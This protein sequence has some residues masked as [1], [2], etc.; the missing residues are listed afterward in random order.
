MTNFKKKAIASLVLFSTIPSISHA[1]FCS[2]NQLPW[3]WW[4]N[5]AYADDATSG[6]LPSPNTYS[7]WIGQAALKYVAT[8]MDVGMGPNGEG[9]IRFFNLDLGATGT[10]AAAFPFHGGYNGLDCAYLIYGVMHPSGLCN[11]T[12]N[13]A[14]YGRIRLNDHY[15]ENPITISYGGPLSVIMHEV[16]HL[17]GWN[18][19]YP[20][21]TS[22]MNQ[23]WTLSSPVDFQIWELVWLNGIY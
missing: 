14:D 10:M 2:P 21:C 12:T 15:M 20:G 6:P 1:Q 9:E 4:S 17:I 22:F 7:N 23:T 5:L 11:W 3:L 18:H 19:S 8:D 13:R 16:G